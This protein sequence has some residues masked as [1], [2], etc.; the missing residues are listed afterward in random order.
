MKKVILA[1]FV[2]F[3]LNF[4]LMANSTPDVSSVAV[5]QRSD[6]SGVVDIY[7]WLSDSDGDVCTVTVQVSN[8][9]GNNWNITPSSSTLSGAIGEVTPSPGAKHILW[10]SKSTL[11]GQYGTNYR[12]KVCAEDNAVTGPIP[13]TDFRRI[14]PATSVSQTTFEMG[15]HYDVGGSDEKPVHTVTLDAFYMAKYEVTN[16]QY[17]DFL[18]E[19]LSAGD[20]IV[21]NYVVYA[22]NDTSK[23]QPYFRTYDSS[24]YSQISYNIGGSFYTRSRD[25]KTMDSHPVVMVSWYGAKAFCDYYGYRLPTE[26]QWECAARGGN[27]YYKYPWGTNTIDSTKCNYNKNNPLGLS[28]Y[29]YTTP[30]GNYPSTSATG[31]YDMAG[32]VWE[33]CEDWY[34]GYP[35]GPVTNPTG[36]TSGS[37][38]VVRG[39]SWYYSDYVCRSAL[40]SWGYPDRTYGDIGFRVCLP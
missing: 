1:I 16:R 40:R 6:G 20:I 11:P 22:K 3:C 13:E 17:C 7:Y 37:Y 23:S 34:G 25:G 30:V 29:P 14:P 19:A 5:S 33:W 10:Q 21:D 24:S 8:D 2:V 15:D 35:S 28:S 18:R 31:L 12:V 32:N 27:L 38:R 4:S 36:P 39:G 9:G 26:A